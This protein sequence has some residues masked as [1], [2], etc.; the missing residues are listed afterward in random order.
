MGLYYLGKN[1]TCLQAPYLNL[2]LPYSALEWKMEGLFLAHLVLK[3]WKNCVS[4]LDNTST[5]WFCSHRLKTTLQIKIILR[6]EGSNLTFQNAGEG[7]LA[8][9]RRLRD[10]PGPRRFGPF[11]GHFLGCAPL[12]QQICELELLIQGCLCLE[13]DL[14]KPRC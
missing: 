7:S 5:F 12:L 13:S 10:I 3:L 11:A 2:A 4:V 6:K 14:Q 8:V 1:F 9:S